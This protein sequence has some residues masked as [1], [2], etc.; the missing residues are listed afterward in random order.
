MKITQLIQELQ[1]ELDYYG[2]TDV[3]ILQNSGTTAF[4]VEITTEENNLLNRIMLICGDKVKD[5]VPTPAHFSQLG[6]NLYGAFQDRWPQHSGDKLSNL[7]Q[8][9]LE[10]LYD[11]QQL[12]LD[13]GDDDANQP[14]VYLTN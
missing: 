6:L 12:K 9:T 1:L 11:I 8:Q 10:P 14:R 3:I 4:Q 2:N 7:V 5:F 13:F